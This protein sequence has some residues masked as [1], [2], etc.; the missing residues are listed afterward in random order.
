MRKKIIFLLF[1]LCLVKLYHIADRRMG[2]SFDLLINSFNKN[3][4]E[5]SSL[6]L[7]ANDY[8]SIRNIFLDKKISEF[9]ISE[10][11]LEDCPGCSHQIVEFTYPILFKQEANIL[12][13]SNKESKKINCEVISNTKLFNIYE[14]K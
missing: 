3:A 1:L 10:Y 2:F 9:K 5:K 6:G 4:G 8:I 13:A 12:I 11:L 14:C 7:F